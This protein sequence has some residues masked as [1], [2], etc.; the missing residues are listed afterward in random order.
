MPLAF[1][2]FR[3]LA[4]ATAL[5]L[6]LC[7]SRPA[8]ATQL[9]ITVTNSQPAGGFGIAPVWIGLHDGTFA[10]FTAGGT[11]SSALESVAELGDNSGL[12]S[13]FNGHGAQTVVGGSPYVPGA[14]A[15]SLLSVA[16]PG[17]DQY[18]SFAAMV[19]PSNDFFM[20][21][22]DP[23]AFHLFDASGNFLGPLTIQVFGRNVWDAGTEVNNID[24]GAAF[25]VG[26]NATDHVAENGTIGPVF[27][28]TT[29]YT[30][31]LNS[32]SG[33]AT[34]GGYD[35]S[36]LISS[37]DLVAT[38]RINAVPEPSAAVLLAVGFAGVVA[39]A[40]RARRRVRT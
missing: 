10:T 18:L 30:A 13:L 15:T 3:G 35:I 38:I 40:R 21:N 23:K 31:Y 17:T 39:V 25:I 28:G 4:L 32:I 29:D 9:Q 34:A 7:D 22:E 26:D 27:G 20:G 6:L 16:N 37:D 14:S 24:F 2:R 33:K 1:P 36:H 5:A 19:V 12:V 11:A 8:R